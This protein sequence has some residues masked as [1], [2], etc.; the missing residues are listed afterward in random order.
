MYTLET[1]NQLTKQQ[2]ATELFKCCGSRRWVE[3][4]TTFFPFKDEKVLFEQAGSIW[5]EKCEKADFLEAF[6]HHP[7][8]GDVENLKK[9]YLITSL[10]ES[11]FM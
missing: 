6:S 2:A 5:Y 4:L 8:I 9:N 7:R 11:I 1:F 3:R 10:N